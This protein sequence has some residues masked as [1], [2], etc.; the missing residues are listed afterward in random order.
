MV[1][2]VFTDCEK[3]LV[4]MYAPVKSKIE[5]IKKHYVDEHG[6]DNGCIMLREYLRELEITDN[7]ST[8]EMYLCDKCETSYW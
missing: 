6:F 8:T 4:K 5:H 1:I 2:C 7:L 3:V